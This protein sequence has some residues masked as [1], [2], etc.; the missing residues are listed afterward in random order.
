MNSYFFKK[1]M[2]EVDCWSRLYT[3]ELI[4]SIEHYQ[5]RLDM[6]RICFENALIKAIHGNDKGDE[7]REQFIK[8]IF[9]CVEE[10]LSDDVDLLDFF[11]D[12]FNSE[13]FKTSVRAILDKYYLLKENPK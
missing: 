11:N 2:T 8:D 12:K 3:T 7:M 5:G 6:W 1:G 13:W 4:E 9:T 10:S